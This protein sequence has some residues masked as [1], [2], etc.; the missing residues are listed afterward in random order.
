MLMLGFDHGS[1]AD[2]SSCRRAID[3]IKN[4]TSLCQEHKI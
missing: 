3:D 4:T 2:F 1:L